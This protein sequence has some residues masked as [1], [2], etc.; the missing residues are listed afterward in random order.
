MAR[1]ARRARRWRLA[2]LAAVWVVALTATLWVAAETKFGPV[3]VTLSFTHGVHLG[4]IA[5]GAA[6]LTCAAAATVA[7]LRRP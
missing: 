3:V 7:L 4:D 6:I 5:F 2:A 1:A